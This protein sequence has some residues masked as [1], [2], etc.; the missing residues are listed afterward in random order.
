MHSSHYTQERTVLVP[1]QFIVDRDKFFD[2]AAEAGQGA[3]L[4][5]D[6]VPPSLHEAVYEAL[7]STTSPDES[8]M[9]APLTWPGRMTFSPPKSILDSPTIRLQ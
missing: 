4:D 2:L 8:G 1:V 6:W 3:G 9:I 5:E 7:I